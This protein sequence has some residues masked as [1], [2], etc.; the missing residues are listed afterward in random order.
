MVRLETLSRRVVVKGR[1]KAV[2]PLHVGRG[3]G[4][5]ELGEA[6]LPILK[7]PDGTPYIPGSTLKGCLRSEVERILTG[8]GIS[9]CIYR[10]RSRN[11]VPD[12]KC[13]PASPCASCDIFGSVEMGSRVVVRD[14]L[15][16]SEAVASQRPGVALE[17]DT[18]RVA[19]G[20]GPFDIEYV[21]PGS[22]FELEIVVENPEDWMLGAIFTA[23]ESMPV[24]GGQ[25]SRGMG[26]VEVVVDRVE[27][28]T[29]E[30]IVHQ[31]PHKVYE[32]DQ[33]RRFIEGCKGDFADS[34]GRLKERYGEL[35]R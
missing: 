3:R 33:V 11:V 29:A 10:G 16:L 7:L 31:R 28:W 20:R 23:L 5:P 32:G 17:R 27:E 9:V 22:E 1:I 4:E 6:D 24:I 8:L 15:P 12:Y 25:G 2:T 13:S 30:S 35:E 18:K 26:K 14:S 34:I 21:K 19:P